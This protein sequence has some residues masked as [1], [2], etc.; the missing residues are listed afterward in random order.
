VEAIAPGEV[1]GR[2]FGKAV[3]WN[4]AG[5]T[6][7]SAPAGELVRGT[8]P[9]DVWVTDQ[10]SSIFRWDGSAWTDK[11]PVGLVPAG[12]FINDFRVLVGGTV[13]AVGG[14]TVLRFDG[15]TWT[16]VPLPADAQP[17]VNLLHVWAS[18][19][20][21][22]WIT[23]QDALLLHWDGANLQRHSY[24]PFGHGTETLESGWA[25]S[26]SDVW[27]GG[28][29]SIGPKLAHFDGSTWTETAVPNIGYA[30]PFAIWGWCPTNVWAV[31]DA[32]FHFDGANW[33]QVRTWFSLYTVSGTGPD[34]IWAAGTSVMRLL[35]TTTCGDDWIGPNED[36]DPPQPLGSPGVPVCDATC[37]IPT[38]GN[39]RIDPGETCDPPDGVSCDGQCHI[40]ARCGDG[41]IGPGEECDPPRPLASTS[42]PVCDST[43]HI[44]T[45]GNLMLDAGETCDPPNGV[46]CDSVCQIIP[47][48]ICGN[49][50]LDPGEDCDPPRAIGDVGVP[51]CD[52]TC[53]I[54]TCGNLTIDPG[55]TCDPPDFGTCDVQCQTM[56]PHCG[57]AI[58][59][60]GEGC[61]YG[62]DYQICQACLGTDCGSCFAFWGISSSA[63]CSGL[64]AQDTI[65]CNRLVGCMSPGIAQCARGTAGIGCYC[66]DLTCSQGA[67]GPCKGPFEALAHTTDPQQVLSQMY[68][69]GPVG[70]VVA[71]YQDFTSI[72]TGCDRHCPPF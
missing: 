57:D 26:P 2:A 30:G 62:K 36:C 66:S 58:V 27:V 19:P 59:Q 54:P 56:A 10:R 33:L 20:T 28:R 15:R 43:C 11:S 71:A 64:N 12:G 22:V 5:W 9:S 69:S 42:I 31:G 52:S 46:T 25:S 13:W 60:A 63:L 34:D 65:S 21:D 1:W 40:P 61:D 44:P 24:G 4:G 48:L 37:H 67:N 47:P 55:E 68:G 17:S 38:C 32:I 35:Q 72:S 45:C 29:S 70:K 3:R 49:S 6:D 16:A 7:M 39:L 50:K 14:S 51:V 8:G 18:G 53:H 23:S 41:R